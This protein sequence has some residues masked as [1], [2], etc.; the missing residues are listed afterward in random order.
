MGDCQ[1]VLRFFALSDDEYI[2]GS[3]NS[4]LNKAMLRNK[5]ASTE[6]IAQQKADFE[7]VIQKARILFGNMPFMLQV[8]EKRE[9]VSIALYDAL[10]VAL[11]RRRDKIPALEPHAAAIQACVTEL[12]KTQREL[13]TGQANTAQA[14]KDRI[15]AVVQ[16]LDNALA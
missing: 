15:A 4:I 2:V 11:Y 6:R 14:I 1:V 3:M 5:D 10:M 16:V 12:K 13:L 8:E 9:R 7:I